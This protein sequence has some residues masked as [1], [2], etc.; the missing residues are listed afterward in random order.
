MVVFEPAKGT[1]M[2]IMDSLD[3]VDAKVTLGGRLG[4]FEKKD[5]FREQAET[6]VSRD[7]GSIKRFVMMNT[8]WYFKKKEKQKSFL[9]IVT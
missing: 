3:I 1:F 8:W 9:R 7:D 5:I 6:K 2:F 4:Y